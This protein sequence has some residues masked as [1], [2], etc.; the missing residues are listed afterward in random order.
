MKV[1]TPSRAYSGECRC[2]AGP[3]VWP[4]GRRGFERV[5]LPDHGR[6]EGHG[7]RGMQQLAAGEI[8]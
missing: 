1:F 2:D 6:R 4:E 8:G 5:A 3:A 7:E